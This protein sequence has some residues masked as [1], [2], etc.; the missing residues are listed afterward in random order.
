VSADASPDSARLG[1]AASRLAAAGVTRP[2]WEAARLLSRARELADPKL[3]RRA[4]DRMIS[5]RASHMPLEYIE[6]RTTFMGREFAVDRRVQ[7]TRPAM[8]AV[9]EISA[10]AASRL[11]ASRATPHVPVAEVG[12]G[13]GALAIMLALGEV[14]ADPVYATDL[15]AD[16]LDVARAN[17]DAAG[18]TDRIV[19]RQG[20]LLDPVPE[21]VGL[22]IANL[23]FVRPDMRDALE[24]GVAEYEPSMAVFGAGASGW[25]LQ[26]ELLEQAGRRAE[27]P[28]V[29]VVTFHVSQEA[30][31]RA[32]ASA[33]FAGYETTVRQLRPGWSGVLLI[34]RPARRYRGH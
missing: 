26:R 31:A 7:V 16:A 24:P 4:F 17:V 9:V 11:A 18:L 5:A 10:L 13:S 30:E 34:S 25:K 22:V 6:G 27:A 2:E 14:A 28:D 15:S 3:A 12:T 8:Q 29:I 33:N 1:S 21:P 32:A 20:S 19:L 23:P